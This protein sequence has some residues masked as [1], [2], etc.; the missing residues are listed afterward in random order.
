MKEKVKNKSKGKVAI[1]AT[2]PVSSATKHK[3]KSTTPVA[4]TTKH[5]AKA[6]HLEFDVDAVSFGIYE[7]KAAY[8]I[9][10]SKVKAKSDV[11][12]ASK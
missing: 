7:T 8:V 5:K 6:K 4:I 3:A 1:T 12:E 2:T 10:F 11:L 9:D